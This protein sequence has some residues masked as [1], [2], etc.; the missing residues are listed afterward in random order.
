MHSECMSHYWLWH[1][2]CFRAVRTTPK[3][4]LALCTSTWKKPYWSSTRP[5][6]WLQDITLHFDVCTI[7][8]QSGAALWLYAPLDSN[9]FIYLE[10]LICKRLFFLQLCKCFV[11]VVLRTSH[12]SISVSHNQTWPA[13]KNKVQW[14]VSTYFV[15][16]LMSVNYTICTIESLQNE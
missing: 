16:S 11:L 7:R 14:E 8:N 15:Q 1:H 4:I 3:P 2:I 9:D 6:N 12:K 13:Q 5:L 10:C